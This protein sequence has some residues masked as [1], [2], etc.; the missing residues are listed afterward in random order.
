MGDRKRILIVDDNALYIDLVIEIFAEEFSDIDF[1]VATNGDEA[2][3]FLDEHQAAPKRLPHMI[4]LDLNL[5][6]LNGI[7]VLDRIKGDSFF[8]RIPVIIFSSSA[9]QDDIAA[10]F[11]SGANAYCVKPLYYD[12]LVGCLEKVVEFW[13]KV[14]ENPGAP[15][16]SETNI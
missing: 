8:C 3:R 11:C 6:G 12:E 16:D 2:L 1:H 5:P 15:L 7:E 4:F 13:F 10:A 9:D 14:S